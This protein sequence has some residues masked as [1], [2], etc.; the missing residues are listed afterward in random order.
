MGPAFNIAGGG[1]ECVA[2]FV[3]GKGASTQ[4]GAK[5]R[6]RS[7]GHV[8]FPLA[9]VPAVVR[10]SLSPRELPRSCNIDVELIDLLEVLHASLW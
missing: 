2:A 9:A 7:L 10:P 3:G 5:V 1:P 4:F 6:R 8:E